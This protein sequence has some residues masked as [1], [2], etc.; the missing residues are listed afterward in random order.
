MAIVE[1]FILLACAWIGSRVAILVR[2]PPLLG[3]IVA[4]GACRAFVLSHTGLELDAFS[5][6]LRLAVLAVVL[7]RAG[8]GISIP[9]LRRAGMLGLRFG[10]VPMLADAFFVTGGAIWLLGMEPASAFVLGFLLAAISPA[11]VIPG[12]LDLL[13]RTP[14]SKKGVVTALLVGAPLDNIAALVGLGIALGVATAESLSFSA[15]LGQAGLSVAGGVVLGIGF[16]WIAS[17]LCRTRVG[18]F[19]G[20]SG[21]L[22]LWALGGAAIVISKAAGLSLVLAIIAIGVTVRALPGDVADDLATALKRIWSF[23]QYALFGLIGAA[24]DLEPLASVGFAVVAVILLGQLGRATGSFM[25]TVGSD[26]SWRERRACAMAYVPKATIQ[27]AFAALPLD[28]G[29]AEGTLIMGAAVL[30]IVVTAPVGVALLHR[31]VG[32]ALGVEE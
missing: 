11:I 19:T 27:A 31:A 32:P 21:A 5:P 10:F 17:R 30:A 4:G 1:L 29:L 7:L 24:V 22:L 3:M 25:A 16:G 12:L 28:R 6:E 26:L 9:D 14:A 8:L 18:F 13:A 2:L 15:Q 23:A 20:M